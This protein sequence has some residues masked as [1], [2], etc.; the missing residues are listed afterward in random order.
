[1][2]KIELDFMAAISA[3]SNIFSANNEIDVFASEFKIF[4]Q[5]DLN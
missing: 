1:M 2:L 3:E 5:I 4:K